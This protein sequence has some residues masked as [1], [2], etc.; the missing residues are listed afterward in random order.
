MLRTNDAK[1]KEQEG[2]QTDERETKTRE[3][4]TWILRD[5]KRKRR[6]N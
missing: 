1:Q 3:R 6:K 2:K 5:S 4:I